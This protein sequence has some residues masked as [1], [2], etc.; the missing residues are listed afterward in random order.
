MD[1]FEALYNI[2]VEPGEV[3]T[4]IDESRPGTLST[5][6][7]NLLHLIMIRKQQFKFQQEVIKLL[8]TNLEQVVYLA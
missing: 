1:N 5:V 2:L 3:G 6:S 4:S 8:E 7:R